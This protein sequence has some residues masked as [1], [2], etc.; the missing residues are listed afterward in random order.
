VVETQLNVTRF[1]ETRTPKTFLSS[2]AMTHSDI[3]LGTRTLGIPTCVIHNASIINTVGA[4]GLQLYNF[5]QTVSLVF[6]NT[7][8]P[9]SFYDRVHENADLGTHMLVLLD[10]NV[11]EQS[12]REKKMH[13][14]ARYTNHLGTC[15]SRRQ[16][17]SSPRSR[18]R[19]KR[20]A[21]T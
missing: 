9:D 21:R 16:W 13:R 6:I 1:C 17:H 15:R 4:C 11:K 14:S 12:K 18:I 10:I 7:W 5:C 19:G 20:C 2:L 3:L 8:R